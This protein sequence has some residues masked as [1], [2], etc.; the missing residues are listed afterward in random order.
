MVWE[1][2]RETGRGCVED[3]RPARTLCT[4]ESKGGGCTSRRNLALACSTSTCACAAASACAHPQHQPTLLAATP[5]PTLST[6]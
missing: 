1:R 6:D 5:H 4:S 2:E 3:H